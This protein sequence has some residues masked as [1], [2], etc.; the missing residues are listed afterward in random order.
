[1]FEVGPFFFYEFIQFV[2]FLGLSISAMIE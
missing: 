2:Y 1:M